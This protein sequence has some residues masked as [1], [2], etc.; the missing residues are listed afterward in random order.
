MKNIS[1][2]KI[3]KYWNERASLNVANPK[4][5][6]NDYWLRVIEIREIKRA[7]FEI[8]KKKNIKNVLDIGCGDGFGTINIFQAFSKLKFLGGDYS[9]EMIKNAEILLEKSKIKSKNI[10]FQLLDVLNLS[11]LTEK[12]D[13]VISDR[14]IINLPNLILQ[15][16]AIKE[17]HQSLKKGGY[18][19]MVENF[20]DGHNNMNKLRKRLGLKEIPIRWHNNFLNEKLL[21]DFVD[22]YFKIINKKNISSIYYLITRI[23]YSKICQIENR[24]PDYDNPIYKIAVD[25]DEIGGNYGPVKLILL[26]KR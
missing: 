14:C 26:K 25:L 6:T 1:I 18:Y 2:E 3:K 15:K 19:I 16:R 5:T 13:V 9:E 23:I 11:S 8:Q 12:F 7:L 20:I 10:S 4:A 17:I 22:H 24:E 21:N